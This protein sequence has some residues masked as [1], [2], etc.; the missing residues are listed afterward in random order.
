M[1]MRM[2]TM[3]MTMTMTMTIVM[4][5][6]LLMLSMMMSTPR[7]TTRT[8]TTATLI[9]PA[10]P[11]EAITLTSSFFNS[12]KSCFDMPLG[13]LKEKMAAVDKALVLAVRVLVAAVALALLTSTPSAPASPI[14][15]SEVGRRGCVHVACG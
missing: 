14:L 6:L 15:D 11:T 4:M 12:A 1:R 8:T 5:L 9:L 2:R 10:N 13:A 7:T 3:T